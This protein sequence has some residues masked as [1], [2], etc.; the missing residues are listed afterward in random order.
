[1]KI[2]HLACAGLILALPA[3]APAQ[4]YPTKPIRLI[5]PLSAGGGMDT[6]ARGI[7]QPLSER[8]KQTVVVDNRP[9]A[10]GAIGA[11]LTAHADPDGYTLLMASASIA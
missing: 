6:T 4:S 7:G 5:V 2:F 3:L 8:L 10:G 1:M 11:E 9:G